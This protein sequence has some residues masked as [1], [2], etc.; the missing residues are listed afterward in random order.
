MLEDSTFGTAVGYNDQAKKEVR[1][2]NTWILA[3]EPGKE[4][5]W[6]DIKIYIPHQDGLAF[7]IEFPNHIA[8]GPEYCANLREIFYESRAALPPLDV[9]GLDSILHTEAPSRPRT[10]R[11]EP[12]YLDDEQIA[13]GEFGEVH[14][15]IDA[16]NGEFYAVKT[17][18]PLPSNQEHGKKRKLDEED[19]LQKVR[20][21]VVIMEKNP[22][23]S[24]TP[25][26]Y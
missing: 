4:T 17:F 23:V 24:V 7:K 25:L 13:R 22:H 11:Q 21:E 9:L 6:K 16:G 5:K 1:R 10:P 19:W 12:V 2:K 18:F 14:R 8:G 3:F 20:N 15:V 26:S